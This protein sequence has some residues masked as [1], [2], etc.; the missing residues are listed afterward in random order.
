MLIGNQKGHGVIIELLA[1]DNKGNMN[2]PNRNP[3]TR[4]GRSESTERAHRRKPCTP[5]H[6]NINRTSLVSTLIAPARKKNGWPIVS[7]ERRRTGFH[8]TDG[9]AAQR[10]DDNMRRCCST[11]LT[12]T[13]TFCH[14]GRC[15]VPP[16]PTQVSR[17][18][19]KTAQS[20]STATHGSACPP[21]GPRC[22]W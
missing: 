12:L 15:L 2:R 7:E 3:A 11:V 16:Q 8:H 4:G 1:K 18:K 22:L 19:S 17:A 9:A 6:P 10:R 14:R 20:H 21:D 5:L 13:A